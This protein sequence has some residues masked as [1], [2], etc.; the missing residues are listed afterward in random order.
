MKKLLYIA[1]GF[2]VSFLNAQNIRNNPTSNHG[3]KFEQLGTILPDANTYRTG[4]GA[5][6]HE[7]W[8]QRADYKIDVE[9]NENDYTISG[10][11]YVTYFNN[12]PD[13]LLYLWFQLDENEHDAKSDNNS[14]DGNSIKTKS[15]NEG[16][17]TGFDR[18]KM[19]EGY[20]VQII[21]VADKNGK[22]VPYT[23]NQTMM[24]V[25]LHKALQPKQKVVL[26][27][28]WKYQMPERMRVGGR[29]GRECFEDGNCIFTVT[30][31]FP[32]LCVYND[33]QGWNNKQFTGRGEFALAFGNYEVKMTV[34]S[35]HII[36]ATGECQ[37]YKEVLT[38]EQFNRYIKSKDSNEPIEIVTREEAL[39]NSLNK[40]STSKKTWH[41]KANNVRDFA[42]GSSRKFVW[43]A[44]GVDI[45]GKKVMAMSY[46]GE[47]AYALYRKYSTKTV[48]HTLRVYSK[49]TIPYPYPVAISVEASNGMEYPMISFNYGRTEKDGTY[50]DRTKY[51]M[52]SVIIHEVGHNFFP[53]IINSDERQWSW[54]DEGLNTFCQ[55]L[56]EQ[57]FD[58]NY[59]S[60]RGPAHKI[61]DY[62]RMPVNQQEPIM[63]NS[64]NIVQFGNNAY[65]KPATA[66]NILRE[67][68]MGRELFD[69]AF[70]EYARRWAFKHPTPADFFRTMEDASGVDLDWFWRG[71][72]FDIEPV[73]IS[74]D[75][76]KVYRF[77]KGTPIPEKLDTVTFKPRRDDTFQHIT[78]I[79]NKQE[80]MEFYVDKDTSLRDY[81]YFND[82]RY[83]TSSVTEIRSR[84]ATTLTDDEMKMYENLYAYELHFTN[85]GGLVM[86]IIIEWTFEDGT[87]E[88]ER[89]NAYIWRKNEKNVSKVFMKNKKVVNILIDPFKETAD[90]DE[91]NNSFPK[92]VNESRIELYKRSGRVA[93]GQS[94]GGNPMQRA[95]N[96]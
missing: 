51:G 44:M 89:I 78:M 59:P 88:I 36:A 74:L 2:S 58:N 52:I 20:G 11:E 13:E 19:L 41:Y 54:M 61:V 69:Y 77:E 70:K 15:M 38:T 81:Y 7:Y 72:F 94:T 90:I 43:D 93:R 75:S 5:P 49:F 76:V 67:T 37:N 35:D 64:E 45:E 14:F 18:A 55:F 80:G 32:R 71:W 56:A 22:A 42:W 4:S 84:T 28:R 96:N 63:T 24:R 50:S 87:K 48:A 73:D 66:L 39:K 10:T 91:S 62:M 27:I 21:E 12:S 60:S 53:M 92:A 40:N 82:Q 9:L 23:I 29:G 16:D 1:L 95:R 68:I 86:P 34:P 83:D 17:L 46:Y 33:Y 25:D 3:N 57:E 31:W 26:K 65:G 8:Q 79:R 30:Q 85:K 6:G 47:E